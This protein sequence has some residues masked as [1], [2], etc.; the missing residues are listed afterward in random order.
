MFGNFRLTSSGNKPNGPRATRMFIVFARAAMAVS[1]AIASIGC[2]SGST[3]L[4][5]PPDGL[6]GAAAED[7]INAPA[8]PGLDGT[9]A[10]VRS[11]EL[12][13]DRRD[14]T[15]TE[16]VQS[17]ARMQAGI[18]K[19]RLRIAGLSDTDLPARQLELVREAI[20]RNPLAL[21]VEPA[22][23]TDTHM[24]EALQKVSADGIPVVLVNRPMGTTG[25]SAAATKAG[26]VAAKGSAASSKNAASSGSSS[27][28]KSHGARPFVLVTPPSFTAPARQLVASA[29]R[30]AKNARLDPKGGAV[31]VINA[32]GDPF[33]QE[34]TTAIF[35]A[36]AESGIT[37]VE[38][39]EFSN[40]AEVGAKLLKEKLKANPKL[41]LVFAIDGL[42]TAASRLVMNELIPDRLFVQSAFAG[43]GN[44]SDMTRVG[45]FAAVAGF[46]PNRVIRKAINTAVRLS[47]GQDLPTR[48][49][50][51]VEVHDSDEKSS[52]P[53]S[54]AYYRSKAASQ[55]KSP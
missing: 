44:Y 32:V 43:E 51:S 11:V 34:R 48:V 52:T 29:I 8:P 31:I 17:A 24:A 39:I 50:L 38:K 13:L 37:T 10:G 35:N 1:A 22:D 28:S 15:E 26:D 18:D 5:P 36:L 40:S 25:L 3:F 55:K 49:E 4:P 20:A 33:S 9:S 14:S 6:R 30:N 45:D 7:T 42:S 27:T 46:V 19:I 21:I 16:L 47:Q 2:D 12:I 41:V 54:P 23:P 53:Q